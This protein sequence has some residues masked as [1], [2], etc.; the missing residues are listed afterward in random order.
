MFGIQQAQKRRIHEHRTLTGWLFLLLLLPA[1]TMAAAS[2]DEEIEELSVE[3][4]GHSASVFALEQK[5][6]HYGHFAY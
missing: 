1:P 5:L 3:V 4:S 2:L 6:L